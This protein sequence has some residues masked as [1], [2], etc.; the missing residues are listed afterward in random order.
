MVIHVFYLHAIMQQVPELWNY[1]LINLYC[2]TMYTKEANL[3]P[4]KSIF[5]FDIMNARIC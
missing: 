3:E 2:V 1:C 5:E 4:I